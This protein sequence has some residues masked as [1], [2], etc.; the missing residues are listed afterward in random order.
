MR[1]LLSTYGSLGD[2]ESIV[3]LA[4]QLGALGAE[5]WLCAPPD[6]ADELI[7]AQFD[8]VA[9]AAAECDARV[10]RVMRTGVWR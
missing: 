10:T 6:C 1:M 2:V 3:G 5:V 9:K 7:A 4:V 8:R